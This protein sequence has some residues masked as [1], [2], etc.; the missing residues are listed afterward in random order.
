MY[1]LL[2][3]LPTLPWNLTGEIYREANEAQGPFTCTGAFQ[4]LGAPQQW[5]HM[6]VTFC[7]SCQNKIVFFLESPKLYKL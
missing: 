2:S 1:L 6:A 4:D 7:E 5:F 3:D